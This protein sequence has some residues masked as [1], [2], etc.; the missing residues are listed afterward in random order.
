MSENIRDRAIAIV[1]DGMGKP[2]A[3][4]LAFVEAACGSDEVLLREVLEMLRS[5]ARAGESADGATQDM[6]VPTVSADLPGQPS[7]GSPAMDEGPGKTIGRY[8][9][10]QLIGEGGFGSVFMAE[11]EQPVRRRV[12]FKII[13][14]GMDTKQVI[15]RFEAERQALAMMDHAHIARV[16]D[17]G[18]TNSGRPYFVM[19]LVKGV[20]ITEY[21]DSQS[22]STRERLELFIPVCNAVQHAHQKGIIHR[23]IKPSN[24]MVT[25]ADGKPVPKVIDFG[26]AKATNARLTEQTYFT[27][28]RQFVGT[29]QYMSPEQAEM[30][31]I[32]TDTRSDIYS[33]GVLLYE[34]LTG[35]TPLDAKELRSQA[36]EEMRRMIR[37]SETPRPSTKFS[38]MGGSAATIAQHRK[39]EP[40]K[41]GQLL[42]GELDWIVMRALEKDR[43][44]RYD[45]PGN[46][47]ADIQRHLDNEP[48]LARPPSR[49]Y[50]VRKFVSKHRGTVL[51]GSA[52]LAALVVGSTLASI[53]LMRARSALAQSDA[54]LKETRKQK[55]IA[56]DQTALAVA[57]AKK[58]DE[59][60]TKAVDNARKAELSLADGLISQADALSLAGRFAQAHQHYTEAYD[61]LAELKVPLRPAGLGLWNSYRQAAFPLLNF[62]LP[63]AERGDQL[64]S[65]AISPDGRTAL[66]G[67]IAT[68]PKLWDLASGTELRTFS[69]NKT[70]SSGMAV[71]FAPDGRTVITGGSVTAVAFAPDGRTALTGSGDGT[72]TLWDVA[73]GNVLRAWL[74][75]PG[76][77]TVPM[78][79]GVAIAPDGRTALSGS[80][81]AT[82]KLWDLATGKELRTFTSP[83]H[84]A[85]C[86]AISPDGKTAL[87][88]GSDFTMRLWDL[89]S[90]KELHTFQ[91]QALVESVESVAYAPNG[92]TAL[93]GGWFRNGAQAEL[94]DLA[95]G[96]K[97]Q[98]FSGHSKPVSS[99]AFSRDGQTALTG[100]G[101]GTAKL[102]DIASGKE[103]RTFIGH[104]SR[105]ASVAFNPDGRTALSGA[106]DG[107]LKLWD[108]A[109]PEEPRTFHNSTQWMDTV[110]AVAPDA[111]T[112]VTGDNE[113]TLKL[114]DL[115]T[116]RELRTFHGEA[117]ASSVV[118]CP[119]GRTALSG[120]FMTLRLWDLTSGKTLRTFT[121]HTQPVV[122]V[123]VAP[124]GRTALSCSGDG[125]I[126]FWELASGRLL[127]TVIEVDANGWPGQVTAIAIAPDGRTALSH[128]PDDRL[129]L[130]DLASGT[131]LRVFGG[132]IARAQSIA[133]S[134][135]GQTALLACSDGTLKLWDLASGMERHTFTGHADRVF[136]A[137]F[138]PDGRFALS[139]SGDR[140][141]KLWDV[142][143][144][145]EVRTFTGHTDEVRSVAFAPNGRFAVSGSSDGTLKLWDFSGGTAQREFEPRVA[146][147]QA[148][149]QHAANDPA[150]LA[151]LGEW[152]A[153][154]G[155]DAWAVDFL[156]RAREGGAGVS[157]LTL[158]R[159]YWNVNR[160]ADARR[161][162]QV[163]L[164]QS[165][166]GYERTYLGWCI[167]RIDI[168]EPF[169]AR[170]RAMLASRPASGTNPATQPSNMFWFNYNGERHLWTLTDPTHWQEAYPD[171]HAASFLIEIAAFSENGKTGTLIRRVRDDGFQV[172]IPPIE[173][174]R[175]L[176]FRLRPG[177]PWQDLGPIH[178]VD[179]ALAPR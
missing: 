46:L 171:G 163:A 61:K 118:V 95:S 19:E 160:D 5:Q 152:Y 28:Y 155:M 8:K 179:D 26:I 170:L 27:E 10:L 88:G 50:A 145:K 146:A 117:R 59:N 161:E 92:R 21:C 63:V 80:R 166:D 72:L 177:D 84:V 133:F 39:T 135:D 119:D 158:A 172:L 107:S 44:R 130:W 32:D 52:V 164:E 142:A 4:R 45:T 116:G 13:K 138:T 12:A 36:Y 140:T 113:G 89:A 108:T 43:T 124:D 37:E 77:N 154:R 17:A 147:A 91:Y 175:R 104:K 82:L 6:P 47:A 86:V 20:P 29:P 137:A 126:R 115:A 9:L 90:G 66:V 136:S 3:Q 40:G 109:G 56:D 53:G 106:T 141:M 25:L 151:T 101:D 165:K 131:A 122:C 74:G 99:V 125:S 102:W 15:A 167:Q 78:V 168:E 34:L 81:D 23:D 129:I 148:I 70:N 68:P 31:G 67:Y 33:L 174:G 100:S 157:P 150:A 60:A 114:W 120:S 98:S 97:L 75:H 121:G 85:V 71:A 128:R 38:G 112:A 127:H 132:N 94:C 110:A 123:A 143:S 153:F 169:Q 42:R 58:A 162:F 83:R 11:Q 62:G 176:S 24:V 48:V 134:P 93:A 55:K 87:S 41:L 144:G 76:K 73:S 1:T 35:T 79:T 49:T 2:E 7:P 156:T 16:F 65:V 96:M 178:L 159:C 30:S 69:G 54:L 111:R 139:G 14:L 64:S 22:L 173:E 57:N 103:L 18:A 105:V 51:A 149:L